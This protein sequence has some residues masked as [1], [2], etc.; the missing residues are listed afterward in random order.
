MAPFMASL[1]E[2]VAAPFLTRYAPQ[3]RGLAFALTWAVIGTGFL[4]AAAFKRPHYLLSVVPAYCLLLAPVIDRLFFGVLSTANRLVRV[5]CYGVPLL[6]AAGA[7]VGGFALQKQYPLLLGPY[8]FAS[9]GAFLV[10]TAA[11][12]TYVRGRRTAAFVLSNLGVPLLLL[13]VW[14]AAS[15]AIEVN[16]EAEALAA[17]F[18]EHGIGGDDEIIS[19]DRRPNASLAFYSGIQ[20]HRLINENEIAGFRHDRLT[21][22]ELLLEESARRM[23]ERLNE[24][25]H[26][27]IV[28]LHAKYYQMLSR[29][30]DFSVQVLFRL[31][32]YHDDAEDELVVVTSAPPV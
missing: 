31:D 30:D 29:R 9:A 11:C 3:R 13:V 10:W 24:T 22:S 2:A 7:V 1:P 8:V 28:I 21:V 14:P 23:Q 16:S 4:S 17:A 32:G 20:I 25:E 26:R 15:K 18:R 27:V 19:A 6:L 12:L 5:T